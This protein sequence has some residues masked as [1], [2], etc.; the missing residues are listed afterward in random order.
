M[1]QLGG[2]ACEEVA[3]A[4]A[5]KPEA[6][7]DAGAEAVDQLADE[8]SRKPVGQHVEGIGERDVGAR[9]AQ[10]LLH[11]QQEDGEGLGHPAR[12][13]VHGEGQ[14][15][16]RVEKHAARLFRGARR[17]GRCPVPR[18]VRAPFRVGL[19]CAGVGHRRAEGEA[20]CACSTS[21][22]RGRRAMRRC[23]EVV[24][25]PRAIHNRRRVHACDPLPRVDRT[26]AVAAC[27]A[28][29]APAA[30]AT[31]ADRPV[32]ARGD[33]SRFEVLA[34]AKAR[35]N[36]RAKVRALPCARGGLRRLEQGAGGGL[37]LQRKDGRYR[38]A[39]AS[40][41]GLGVP[42]CSRACIHCDATWHRLVR[43]SGRGRPQ[44]GDPIELVPKLAA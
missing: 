26:R 16:E 42:S 17:A 31:C 9:D 32:T 38:V 35:G 13:E 20:L 7:G 19:E 30:A 41:P 24:S 40:P 1:P 6:V 15:D 5:C 14:G 27:A 43:C 29:A 34:K 21:P 4:E 18:V 3:E 44:C 10:A 28:M 8:R 33:P 11:R 22:H 37:P 23:R 39:V 2:E 36:W 12:D 25:F